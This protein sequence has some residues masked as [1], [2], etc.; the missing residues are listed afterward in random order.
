MSVSV[1][2]VKSKIA[3]CYKSLFFKEKNFCLKFI[4]FNKILANQRLW[5][6]WLNLYTNLSTENVDYATCEGDKKV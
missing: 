1:A 6:L 3:N 4:T 5:L 2:E